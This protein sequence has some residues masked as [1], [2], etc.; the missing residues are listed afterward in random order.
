M[1]S[2]LNI[3]SKPNQY[4]HTKRSQTKQIKVKQKKTKSVCRVSYYKDVPVYKGVS[5]TTKLSWKRPATLIRSSYE[6]SERKVLYYK[7]MY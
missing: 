4:N 3:L 1:L 2:H 5:R 7:Y 6:S